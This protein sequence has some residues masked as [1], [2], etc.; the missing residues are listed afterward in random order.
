MRETCFAIVIWANMNL[1]AAEVINQ[2]GY[3]N[4]VV[5]QTSKG[6]IPALSLTS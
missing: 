3:V 1:S 2:S 6:Q 5:G 4:E